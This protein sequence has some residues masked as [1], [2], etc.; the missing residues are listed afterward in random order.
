MW[1]IYSVFLDIP[2]CGICRN[3]DHVPLDVYSST[4]HTRNPTLLEKV[5]VNI[6]LT[7]LVFSF[8]ALLFL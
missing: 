7:H 1:G 4:E 5:L 8:T 6:D 2:D 3:F